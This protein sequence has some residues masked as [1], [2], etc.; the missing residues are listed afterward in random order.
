MVQLAGNRNV[1]LPASKE[2]EDLST[3]AERKP[4]KSNLKEAATWKLC[5]LNWK[6]MG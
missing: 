4:L 1:F 2:P 3:S 6:N 5:D